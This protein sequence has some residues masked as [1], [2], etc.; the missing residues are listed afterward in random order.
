MK[1]HHQKFEPDAPAFDDSGDPE[2]HSI[3]WRKIAL[4]SL[5]L[6]ATFLLGFLA[7]NGIGLFGGLP[8]VSGGAQEIDLIPCANGNIER[9]LVLGFPTGHVVPPNNNYNVP[10]LIPPTGNN[11]V[12]FDSL[13]GGTV[14]I[15]IHKRGVRRVFTLIQAYGPTAGSN[16]LRVE[17]N[18]SAGAL[19]TFDLFAGEQV[20]DFFESR[21]EHRLTSPSTRSAFQFN[22]QGAAFSSLAATG[23]RGYYN[24]DEQEFVLGGGFAGQELQS[25]KLTCPRNGGIAML[26]GLTV[27]TSVVPSPDAIL[28]TA[29]RI[30]VL[31]GGLVLLAL[32]LVGIAAFFV[33]AR[34][35]VAESSR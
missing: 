28:S 35:V 17:F 32:V 14:T 21:Y 6:S 12:H 5:L 27:D 9:D 29:A 4:G 31:A 24:F 33:T 8:F 15:P 18:G 23:W 11:F 7:A 16:L 25:V 3:P 10:F 22:G 1:D 34:I 2:A 20:R 13:P 26:L 19:Q 30:S